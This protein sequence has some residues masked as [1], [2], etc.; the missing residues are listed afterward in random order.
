MQLLAFRLRKILSEQ[1]VAP[2][3]LV[4]S[5]TLAQLLGRE[6]GVPTQLSDHVRLVG[7][8]RRRGKASPIDIAFGDRLVQFGIELLGVAKALQVALA[9]AGP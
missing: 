6:T 9:D 1:P 3:G 7:K 8:P 5:G 2:E 4:G